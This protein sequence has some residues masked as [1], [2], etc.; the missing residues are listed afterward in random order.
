MTTKRGQEYIKC[1]TIR[2]IMC[3][4]KEYKQEQLNKL[5]QKELSKILNVM[6]V[7]EGTKKQCNDC[8]GTG[9]IVIDDNFIK[10]DC[11]QGTGYLNILK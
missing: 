7:K 8:M 2:A 4:T 9:E 6:K 10:C 5:T 1:Q 11:C 3:R